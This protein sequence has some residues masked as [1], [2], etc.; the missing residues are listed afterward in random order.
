MIYTTSCLDWEDK[1]VARKSLCPLPLF[2]EQAQKALRVFKSLR[3]PDLPNQPKIGDVTEQWVFDFVACIFGA[4][5]AGT[6]QRLIKRFFLLISKKNTKSFIAAAI[7]L[8]A[9]II[10][11]R[12]NEPF[13]IIAPT[14]EIANNSFNPAAAMVKLE[15]FLLKH[16]KVRDHIKTIEHR[17]NGNYL[18]VVAAESDTVGGTTSGFVLVDELWLFGSRASAKSMIKEAT[19]GLSSKQD[20]FVIYLSTQSDK[21]PAGIFKNELTYARKVR[22]GEVL[23][24][25]YLPILYEYPKEFI[26]TKKYLDPKYFYITNPNLG[27]SKFQEEMETEFNKDMLGDEETRNIYLAKHLNIEIDFSLADNNWAGGEYWKSAELVYDLDFLL[28]NMGVISIGIDGGGLDDLL[29]L[30]LIGRDEGGKWYGW[31]KAWATYKALERRKEIAPRLYDFA[32]LGEVAIVDNIGTDL[33]EL[34]DIVE[35]VNEYGIIDKVGCDPSGI[36]DILDG[37]V[38]RGIEEDKLVGVSQGWRLGGAIKTA[39]RRLADGSFKVARQEL[40]RW[41]VGNAK[42]EQRANSILIT[43]QASGTA[44]IDPLMAM[45][46]AVTLMAQNPKSNFGLRDFFISPIIAG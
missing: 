9:M 23:D 5:D 12:M 26:D 37:L 31:G 30:Y 42:V 45:F 36:G 41:C 8:T 17:T 24:R 20:G 21:A 33:S 2:D 29:G 4:Y 14:K 43:K 10:T 13:I 39:E 1:I 6:K 38:D 28:K 11:P 19:G 27:V 15:P 7:M 40:M 32:K 34:L 22:D 18:K 46:N 35:M 44:K 25:T 16:F 3:V